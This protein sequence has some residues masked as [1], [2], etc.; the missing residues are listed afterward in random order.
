M[1][2]DNKNFTLQR[3]AGFADNL[4]LNYSAFKLVVTRCDE[5]D[6]QDDIDCA[7]DISDKIGQIYIEVVDLT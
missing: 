4:N 7:N 3:Q 5:V 6:K 1:C 2:A